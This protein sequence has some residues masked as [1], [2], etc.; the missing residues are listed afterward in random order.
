MGAETMSLH[1]KAR[2][3]TH[4]QLQ[5]KGS[6]LKITIVIHWSL[7]FK[8]VFHFLL[9]IVLERLALEDRTVHIQY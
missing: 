5:G 8:T 1:Q 6:N 7:K 3:V 2:L 9:K 4:T